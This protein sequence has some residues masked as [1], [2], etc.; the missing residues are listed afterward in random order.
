MA[1]WTAERQPAHLWVL[2]DLA[3]QED[4]DALHRLAVQLGGGAHQ[5]NVAHLRLRTGNARSRGTVE[6]TWCAILIG[7]GALQADSPTC[8]CSQKR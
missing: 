1:S 7:R 4:L 5:A 8:A 3:A 6:A 2:A